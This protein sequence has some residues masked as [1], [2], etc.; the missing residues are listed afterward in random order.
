MNG[1]RYPRLVK[2]GAVCLICFGITY[3]IARIIETF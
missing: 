2:F 3:G 1:S